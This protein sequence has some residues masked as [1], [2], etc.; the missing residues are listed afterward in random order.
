MNSG[1]PPQQH[2]YGAPPTHSPY[3]A[4]QGY[5]APPVPQHPGSAPYSQQG[6]A[7]PSGPP[8]GQY[9]A[10]PG[11]PP[12]QYGA[13]QGP[14][15]GQ[16]GAPSAQYGAPPQGHYGA[17]AGPP[18]PPSLGYVP[19]QVA[20]MDLSREADQVR[21]AMK[22]FGTD[23][24]LLIQVLSRLDPLQAAGVRQTF[25]QRHRRDLLNDLEKE[26]SGYFR[27]GLLAIAR[28]P[29][30]QDCFN[31]NKAI[32]GLGTK[33]S[34]VNDVLLSRSNADIN[35]I[36]AHYQHMFRRSLE[37]DLKGDLSM[38]T[39]RLFTMILAARR[40]EESSPVIPQQ[41]DSDVQELYRATEGQKMGTDQV[42]V[43]SI[44]SSRSDGQIRAISL[45]YKQKYHRALGEVLAKNFSG[46]ME[47]A[48]LFMLEHA[49]DRAKHD[50][51]LLED[52]MK[53]LGTK[54]DLLVNRTIRI[55]WD[56]AR[57]GQ[58]RA[59]YRHFYKQD[60]TARIRG[61]TR[62]DYERLMVACV[63]SGQ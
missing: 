26:T 10:P 24:K 4:Q 54:D 50:A 47:D 56:K 60:L 51:H 16:Y 11:P 14:P 41:I 5:G 52:S 18:A 22:G 40:N 17:P 31:L 12:G 21:S 20:P 15:P 1:Y 32:K 59:A 44:L 27:D 13:P 8:P 48:L 30:E 36:K 39:E 43:C 19:G 34:V 23:E 45:A 37:S 28:G 42:T 33:E 2:G 29:L 62:G 38:K 3:P 55:H 35:A 25:N 57:M 7:P 9:G 53:G 61:E 49:E 58:A 63:E 6:F 46:H